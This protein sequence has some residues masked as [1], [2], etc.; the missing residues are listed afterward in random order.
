MRATLGKYCCC[1]RVAG[2]GITESAICPANST[3]V[4]ASSGGMKLRFLRRFAFLRRGVRGIFD[5]AILL[6]FG[7][8]FGGEEE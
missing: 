4:Y 3:D 7:F 1:P 5:W 8:F 2:N 6:R